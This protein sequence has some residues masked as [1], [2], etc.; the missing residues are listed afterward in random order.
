MPHDV[1]ISYSSIDKPTADAITA[2]LE[3]NG[4]RC[5]I[6]PRDILPGSDW[7]EAIVEAIEQAGTMV[8]VFS[9]HAN[10]SP[11]IRREIE[12]AVDT[13][14]PLIPFRI[15]DVLPC[16]S[17]QYFIGP[18]H[19]L[20]AW[21]PPL[22][23][24]LHRLTGTIKALLSKR[25]E[26]FDAAGREPQLKPPSDTAVAAPP[27][28][29]PWPVSLILS[30]KLPALLVLGAALVLIF[31]GGTAYRY[32]SSSAGTSDQVSLSPQVVIQ[33]L[34]ER[35]KEIRQ[36]YTQ[37]DQARQKELEDRLTKIEGKY[38]DLEKTR[39]E[40]EAKLAEA[41]RGLGSLKQAYPQARLTQAKES[42]A[43]GDTKTAESLFRQA[44]EDGKANPGEAAYQLGV[45]AESRIDYQ[46][47]LRYYQE[48]VRLKPS[49][50]RNLAA[51]GRMLYELGQ[52]AEAEP[53][54]QRALKI[55]EK[56]LGPQ[57]PDVAR[58]LNNLALLYY[59]QG[60]YGE[61]EPLY[62]RGQKIYEKVL[63]PEHP[64]L[65]G[66]LNNLANLYYAQRKYGEAEPLYQQALKIK[67]KALGPEHPS[68]AISLHNLALLY[69]AQGKYG[70]AEP[71]YQ[72]ALKI[73]ERVLGPEHPDLARSLN[74][75]AELYRA[76]GKYGEAE[77][78]YQQA[79]KIYEKALGPEHPDLARSLGGLANLY[80]V[81]GKYGEAE[82]LYQRAL[83]IREKALGP[84][85]PDLAR[86]FNNLAELNRAQGKYAE[87]EPLYQQA[88]KIY[89]KALGPEHPDV[90]QVLEN[91]ASLLTKMGQAQE[92]ASLGARAQAIREKPTLQK[93]QQ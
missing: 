86:S 54:Y 87:A 20:D 64:D 71:L 7:S 60:K 77:P 9:A 35:E 6:A 36:E 91:Y 88:L 76:Q 5:W 79:L 17:L 61:A 32:L 27:R 28:K 83:K 52:Y 44:L 70:E 62:Q 84:E 53:L 19:W 57:H 24:H 66:S 4:I 15:E 12:R 11:Q 10:T 92:A 16:R 74:N 73:D 43:R 72:R 14:I 63:G 29:L 68:V 59:A 82:P 47:A 37:A 21:T 22:E 58:S 41:S 49:N 56:A 26:G 34:K 33:L 30:K 51:A 90:A 65:A 13:G 81:Q 93:P 67:E 48:A 40:L 75:L 1:F 46:S 3:A 85:H 45:L 38:R 50:S 39:G 89:E 80:F 8:L 42:L 25:L 18:Q 78:L 31:G 69:Y 23:Q 2:S 55:D